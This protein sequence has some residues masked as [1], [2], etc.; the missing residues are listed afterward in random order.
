MKNIIVDNGTKK[1]FLFYIKKIGIYSILF[2][3]ER[4]LPKLKA[5]AF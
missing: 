4:N 5:T 2:L 3:S 1:Y